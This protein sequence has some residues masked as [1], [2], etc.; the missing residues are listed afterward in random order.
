M[1]KTIFMLI[2]S[3]IIISCSDSNSPEPEDINNYTE[4]TDFMPLTEGTWWLYETYEVSTEGSIS[5]EFSL[6]KQ[7]IIEVYEIHDTTVCVIDSEDG[8]TGEYINT[9][10]YRF[11]DNKVLSSQFIGLD[12]NLPIIQSQLLLVDY[13]K[14]EWVVLDDPGLEIEFLG[15]II[16]GEITG[17]AQKSYQEEIIVN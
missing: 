8:Q 9:N 4:I 16:S 1:N 17:E 5:E 11:I 12:F 14:N 6:E 3:M 15:S 10:N 2:F 7:T 13:D